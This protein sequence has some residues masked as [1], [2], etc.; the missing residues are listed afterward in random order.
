MLLKLVKGCA[1]KDS[2]KTN[3]TKLQT[4]RTRGLLQ[5]RKDGAGGVLGGGLEIS[6]K[7]RETSEE[8]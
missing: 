1:V 5:G 3:K 7:E 4:E 6:K 8:N 2:K